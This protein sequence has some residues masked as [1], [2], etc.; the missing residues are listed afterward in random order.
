MLTL[1]N[2]QTLPKPHFTEIN[3]LP[4]QFCPTQPR[5]PQIK[6]RLSIFSGKI[7]F[8]LRF[9]QFNASLW[10]E[11]RV[12]VQRNFWHLFL[13]GCHISINWFRLIHVERCDATIKVG[14]EWVKGQIVDCVVRNL[15]NVREQ[16][17]T[18]NL[19]GRNLR[20][21]SPAPPKQRKWVNYLFSGIFYCANRKLE[22][23]IY[24]Q[25]D[26]C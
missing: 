20:V 24:D 2:P 9:P 14:C 22:Q 1:R 23:K 25:T 17:C 19:Q 7:Q 26:N 18:S 11:N 10:I 5:A 15:L 6:S 4:K 21:T 16:Q 3:F 8:R 12:T 13:I